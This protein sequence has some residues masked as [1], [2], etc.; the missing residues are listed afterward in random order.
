[1]KLLLFLLP[2]LISCQDTDYYNVARKNIIKYNPPRK[3][4][5]IIIDYT[6][7]ILDERLYVIEMKSRNVVIKSKVSH[8]FKS[9]I[10]Y[11]RDF[12]N[13]RGTNKSSKGNFLTNDIIYSKFGK[14]MIIIGLDKGINN[15]VKDRE[16]I[17]HSDKKM[18]TPWSLGCFATPEDINKQIIDLTH[19]GCLVSVIN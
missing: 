19:N 12:S 10:L 1:M 4:Y 17:F 5:V 3:D 9:G 6:K 18:S 7:S 8:A 16:I 14:S 15:N 2:V 11:A 13:V